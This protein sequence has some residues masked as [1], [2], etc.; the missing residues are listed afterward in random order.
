MHQQPDQVAITVAVDPERFDEAVGGLTRAG[1][2]VDQ[3]HREIGAVSGRVGADRL[4]AVSRVEGV[5]AVDRA[6][7]IQLPPPDAEVQ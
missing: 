3:E 4:P 6:A 5:L 2:T 7:T 1:V